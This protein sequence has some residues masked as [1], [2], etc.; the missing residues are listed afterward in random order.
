MREEEKRDL[1][2]APIGLHTE[3]MGARGWKFESDVSHATKPELVGLIQST[4]GNR[5]PGISTIAAAIGDIVARAP[6]YHP[7]ARPAE[8]IWSGIKGGYGPRYGDVGVVEYVQSL[9]AKLT[10]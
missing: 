1:A 10:I 8:Y 7:E 9:A 4:K 6:P 3:G 2:P 5:A